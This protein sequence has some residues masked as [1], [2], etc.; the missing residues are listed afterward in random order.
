M[1]ATHL[2]GQ[3]EGTLSRAAGLVDE[4]ET[5]LDGIAA[6]LGARVADLQARWRGAGA[7]AFLAF[8]EAWDAR[9]GQIV[10]ALEDFAAALRATE[11]DN[12]ATDEAQSAVYARAA[13]AL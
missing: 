1:S 10:R 13:Q 4:A 9:Q 2:Y 7:S 12:L 6:Q 8:H 11:R 5:D 3:G